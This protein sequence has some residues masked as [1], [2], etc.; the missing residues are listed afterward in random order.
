MLTRRYTTTG[1]RRE[2]GGSE[3]ELA[4]GA[5]AGRLAVK[6]ALCPYWYVM[7][8][9]A[10][11]SVALTCPSA[12]GRSLSP[13]ISIP[14]RQQQQL[15]GLRLPRSIF[16]GL[17]SC[18]VGCRSCLKRRAGAR[19]KCIRLGTTDGDAAYRSMLILVVLLQL[20]WFN[21]YILL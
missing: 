13:G 17:F 8:I 3:R 7:S 5:D 19:I 12:A 11:T 18:Q 4:Y 20:L 16:R 10:R 9:H 6:V 15:G 14:A 21:S 1:H 2:R